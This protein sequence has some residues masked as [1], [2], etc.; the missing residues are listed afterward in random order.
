[1]KLIDLL[2]QH[3]GS[4]GGWPIGAAVCAQDNDGEVCFYENSLIRRGGNYLVWLISSPNENRV[5]KR[6]IF[7]S[8]AEDMTE[9]IINREQY[10]SALAA[11][12][13]T[14]WSG[15]GLPPVGLA[16]EW[17]ASGDHDWMEVKVLAY[18][19]D[20]VWLQPLNGAQSFTVG[21]P[22]DFRPIRT[23][24]ERKREEFAHA[25]IAIDNNTNPSNSMEFFCSI[26]DAIAAGKIPGIRL[27]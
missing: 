16:C 14:A 9:S 8:Q 11:S 15:E 19:E 27:E 6:R 24:A 5:V 10:E 7:M 23:E 26:Y 1:M 22:D 4:N 3:L 18:H 12:K 25:C 20:E 21:N 13:Q 2:V 17:L